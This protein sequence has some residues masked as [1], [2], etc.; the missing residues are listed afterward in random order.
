MFNYTQGLKYIHS[1]GLA[2]LDIKP[3]RLL[4]WTSCSWAVF[5]TLTGFRVY[6]YCHILNDI[7]HLGVSINNFSNQNRI[8]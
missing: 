7:M 6:T 3:G 8:N 1:L 2:H 5:Y 4:S